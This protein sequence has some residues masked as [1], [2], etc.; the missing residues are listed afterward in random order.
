MISMQR[1]DFVRSALFGGGAVCSLALPSAYA[2]LKN[3]AGHPAQTK[4]ARLEARDGIAQWRSIERCSSDACAAAQRVRITIDSLAFPATFG[5]LLID[6]M[7][8]TSAGV[9]PF[10]VASHQ[11][12]SLSPSSKPFSFE[13][14]STA[15]AGFRAEHADAL[16]GSSSVCAASLLGASRP[17][18]AAGRYLL[19]ISKDA[20]PLA[21][22]SMATPGEDL[23][24]V[25]T[26]NGEEANF[27]WLSFTV[28]PLTA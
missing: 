21:I 11:P 4:L 25:P 10:R 2:A 12:D 15:L 6:A 23:N 16:S 13:A 1:R 14:D 3:D 9:K 22:E 8:D 27:A 17:V 19:V 7:F 26:R 28:R 20:N 5:A 24:F 18:L